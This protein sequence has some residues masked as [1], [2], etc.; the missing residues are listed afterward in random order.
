MKN[1]KNS[2]EQSDIW[3][4]AF[5]GLGEIIKMIF[6]VIIAIVVAGSKTTDS[7]NESEEDKI[8][9]AGDRHNNDKTVHFDNDA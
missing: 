7:V 3:T 8:L 5:N 1:D 4:V 9:H 6:S 2:F